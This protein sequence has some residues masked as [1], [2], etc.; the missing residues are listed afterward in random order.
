MGVSL[1]RPTEEHRVSTGVNRE[2]LDE[3]L[4]DANIPV[5]DVVYIEQS[6]LD[7]GEMILVAFTESRR[8]FYRGIPIATIVH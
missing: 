1:N 8:E 5:N 2:L 4:A 7:N 3:L 6:I